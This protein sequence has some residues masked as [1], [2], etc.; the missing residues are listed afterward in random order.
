VSTP[1]LAARKAAAD[2][3]SAVVGRQISLADQLAAST[4]PLDSLEPSE[5]ARAQALATGTLRHLERIDTFLGR[6]LD[7]TPPKPAQNALRLAVAEIHLDHVPAHAA[8]DAAVRLARAHPKTR[9]LTGLVNAVARRASQAAE[10]W[11]ETPDAEPA[12]WIRDA[13]RN[14]YG[15]DAAG[16]IATA[17]RSDP[18]VDLTPRAPDSADRLAAALGAEVLP[19]GSLR[20]HRPGQ[21]SGLSGFEGG[22]WW[23][24]DA[25]AALPARLLADAAGSRVLDL[26]AAP[27]GKTLQLAAGGAKVTALDVSKARLARLRDNL[28]RTGLAAEVIAADALRWAPNAPFDAILLDAPCTATGTIRRHPDL[29]YIRRAED[30]DALTTL[31][32]R[33]LARAWGWLRPGGRLVF[34]TCSL[35]PAECELQVASFMAATPE[36]IRTRPDPASLGVDPDWIDAEGGLRLRPDYWPEKGGMD[37]FFAALLQKT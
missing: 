15:P 20:L 11:S 23:V 13:I 8:V 12:G 24:Q 10:A 7:R 26:C 32:S 21:I 22:E 18:P 1:G 35:L 16:A 31:Q 28:A 3:L 2:L 30:L 27:G 33:L 6:F 36:A 9:H 4:T 14:T 25:A 37:G 17:H 19:T 29:P 34:C 5:R